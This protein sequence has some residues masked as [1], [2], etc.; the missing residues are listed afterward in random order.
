MYFRTVRGACAS[1]EVSALVLYYLIARVVAFSTFFGRG[2]ETI[3]VQ[4]GFGMML[5]EWD[6]KVVA[7][8][9]KCLIFHFGGK[10]CEN[11]AQFSASTGA[12]HRRRGRPKHEPPNDIRFTRTVFDY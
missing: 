12:R 1:P 10:G 8:M 2:A 7:D 3:Q 9:R 11:D 4:A 6:M 5:S